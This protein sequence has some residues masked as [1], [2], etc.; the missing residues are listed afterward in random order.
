MYSECANDLLDVFAG[1]SGK[2][3]PAAYATYMPSQHPHAYKCMFWL[4]QGYIVKPILSEASPAKDNS[5]NAK[6]IP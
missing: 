5:A 3:H 4:Q 6:P 1:P 2:A